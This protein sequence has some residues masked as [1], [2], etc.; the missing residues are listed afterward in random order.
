VEEIFE[1]KKSMLKNEVDSLISRDELS[2]FVSQDL[3]HFCA[4]D[5]QRI[6]FDPIC[7]FTSSGSNLFRSRLVELSVSL[8]SDKSLVF[9]KQFQ[10]EISSK[11]SKF[12]EVLHAG[13]LIIDDIQDGSPTRRGK[14]S[15]HSNIGVPLAINSGSWLYFW[16]L[17]LIP[18]MELNP[19]VELEM[20]R[21]CHQALLN[22][23]LGQALDL[24]IC[25]DKVSQDKAKELSMAAMKLKTGK[26]MSLAS[27]LS[28]VAC[29]VHF[30]VR[31]ALKNFGLDFGFALQSFND[32]KEFSKNSQTINQDL[33]LGRPSWIW[34]CAS[35]SLTSTEYKEFTQIVSTLRTADPSAQHELMS[36][37]KNH[38][39]IAY[40][41]LQ[42][43]N[44][45]NQSYQK[46]S[47]HLMKF[48]Y[49][50]NQRSDWK[51]LQLLGKK[52][53]ETYD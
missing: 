7:N 43:K 42:A 6:V 32:L 35:E 44:L 30:E 41:R 52:V 22:G 29:G 36:Q 14:P 20:T 51:E 2:N 4:S 47:D 40:A 10:K 15:L 39:L 18:K 1:A 28:A 12:L 26:L 48:D 25:I 8:C 49:E 53:M 11:L 38:S 21:L 31:L 5:L 45:M 34:V 23:H 24:G 3:A 37:F 46:L 9:T 16:A 17:S 50:L 19:P 13:S 27:E 33:I